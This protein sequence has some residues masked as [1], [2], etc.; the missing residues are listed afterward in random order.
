MRAKYVNKSIFKPKSED[1]IKKIVKKLS[2][3]DMF[4]LIGRALSNQKLKLAKK[5]L[6][7]KK[8]NIFHY[9][10]LVD[11]WELNV[12]IMQKDVDKYESQSFKNIRD[13]YQKNLDLLYLYKPIGLIKSIK[14]YF[15][16]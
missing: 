12:K 8:L 14:N 6:E 13:R 11:H 7:L 4:Y 2:S 9:T 15:Q 1:D 5:Y 10:Q 16:K 3:H